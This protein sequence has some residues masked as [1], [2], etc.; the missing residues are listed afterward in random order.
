MLEMIG[1]IKV[2]EQEESVYLPAPAAV[3]RG[4]AGKH[5][6][7]PDRSVRSPPDMEKATQAC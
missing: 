5:P 4:T 6:E 2:R 1:L 7:P 3:L